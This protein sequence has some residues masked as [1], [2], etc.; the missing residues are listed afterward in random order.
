MKTLQD[1]TTILKNHKN[2]FHTKYHI[3]ELAIFGS[4]SRGENTENSDIDILFDYD[5]QIGW[6]FLRFATELEDLLKLKVD[7]VSKKGIKAKY[8]TE[9]EKELIYV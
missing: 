2:D 4:Y 1:I 9:I 7:L 8:F 5:K 3:S 6:E